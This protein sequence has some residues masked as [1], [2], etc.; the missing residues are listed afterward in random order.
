MFQ[1]TELETWINDKRCLKMLSQEKPLRM[2]SSRS[3]KGKMSVIGITSSDPDK[4]HS[5][6]TEIL[7]RWMSLRCSAKSGTWDLRC[8]AM[9]GTWDLASSLTQPLSNAC[10][11]LKTNLNITWILKKW[12]FRGTGGPKDAWTQTLHMCGKR[13]PPCKLLFSVWVKS[14]LQAGG[15]HG[16]LLTQGWGLWVGSIVL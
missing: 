16:S 15:A 10:T 8:S 13:T 9:S 14:L 7:W 5:F 1:D 2:W 11:G 4:L 6:C 3:R 12:Q